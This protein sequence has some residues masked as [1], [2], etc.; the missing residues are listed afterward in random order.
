MAYPKYKIQGLIDKY[1]D[2]WV[3]LLGLKSWKLHWHVVNSYSKKGGKV[4]QSRTDFAITFFGKA[5]KEA[6]I[7]VNYNRIPNK[8]E[9]IA[10]IIHEL[11][12]VRL[13]ALSEMIPFH[14]EPAAAS[15]EERTVRAI[16]RLCIS[17]YKERS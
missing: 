1:V 8:N 13:A 3:D 12:H 11:M 15:C 4:N 10:T 16:E 17:L 2:K 6:D 7:V 5:K 9:A 14:K